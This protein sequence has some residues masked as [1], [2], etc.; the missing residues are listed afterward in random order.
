[1]TDAFDP[2][3]CKACAA[4]LLSLTTTELTE[5]LAAGGYTFPDETLTS[6]KFAGWT[7]SGMAEWHC[8]WRVNN[9]ISAGSLFAN[10][11]GSIFVV[12]DELTGVPR[13]EF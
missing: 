13:A 1:M 10:N 5:A 6:A 12:V 3:A 7:E 4:R 8:V 9:P 2:P 11:C